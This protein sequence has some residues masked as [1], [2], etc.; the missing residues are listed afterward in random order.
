MPSVTLYFAEL[1]HAAEAASEL[2]L[3]L[4]EHPHQDLKV[5]QACLTRVSAIKLDA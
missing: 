5:L 3:A 2:A 4:I 1:M